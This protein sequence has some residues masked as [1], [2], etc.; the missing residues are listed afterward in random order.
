MNRLE[1]LNPRRS[2][3]GDRGCYSPLIHKGV[4]YHI[5][6]S[7]QKVTQETKWLEEC[8]FDRAASRKVIS[9]NTFATEQLSIATNGE[10]AQVEWRSRSE[11]RPDEVAPTSSCLVVPAS[12]LA[13]QT[14]W[15][16]KA[17]LL[18]NF[19]STE[20][21]TA[22]EPLSTPFLQSLM[23]KGYLVSSVSNASVSDAKLTL[24]LAANTRLEKVDLNAALTL[25]CETLCLTD[26][27]ISDCHLAFDVQGG[28][29]RDV[30]M[31][32]KKTALTGSLGATVIDEQCVFDSGYLAADF[33]NGTLS[34][35]DLRSRLKSMVFDRSVMPQELLPYLATPLTPEQV[36]EMNAG[37]AIFK[38]Q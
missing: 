7:I 28:T 18:T 24:N 23:E 35:A 17:E 6:I 21:D 20:A 2:F 5:A 37:I 26:V 31:S 38:P 27:N 19:I 3:M 1:E 29:W 4:C 11:V 22:P 12:D 14:G 15:D 9:G 8:L 30:R 32:G 25:K 16:V 34:E 13:K 33:R 10:S 36:A